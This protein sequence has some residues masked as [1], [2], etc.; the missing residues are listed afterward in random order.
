MDIQASVERIT[1][2]VAR[3]WL[4]NH[5]ADN[6]RM[7][8]RKHVQRLA[9]DMA[10]GRWQVNGEPIAFYSDGRLQNGQ[11][12]LAAI[13]QSGVSL[14]MLVVRGIAPSVTLADAGKKRTVCDEL[15][16]MK[17]SNCKVAAGVARWVL[18][19]N[20]EAWQLNQVGNSPKLTTQS[21]VECAATFREH[22]ESAASL[23]TKCHSVTS[24]CKLS[25][26]IVGTVACLAAFPRT[27]QQV[28]EVVQFV[29]AIASGESLT[30][31]DPVWHLRGRYLRENAGANKWGR[32]FTRAMTV[33]AWNK[34]AIGEPTRQL[35]FTAIGPTAQQVPL[36][37][38]VPRRGMLPAGSMSGSAT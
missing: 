8:D 18:A 2:D 4:S 31:M 26:T 36:V 14:Q 6:Y 12:R 27:A 22:I 7:M 25:P 10:A 23:A 35:K 24:T 5:N 1:P 9:E 11:H 3:R 21:V 38:N 16:R 32:E 17:Y 19:Y 33:V 30:A 15:R 29:S 13:V 20:V 34:H 37:Y 28:G